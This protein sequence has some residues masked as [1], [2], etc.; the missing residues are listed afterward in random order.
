MLFL[1]E[2]LAEVIVMAWKVVFVVASQCETGL[3]VQLEE[4]RTR[5]VV[6]EIALSVP[7]CL[8]LKNV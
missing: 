7:T 8:L 5:S 2:L 1:T 3:E 6:A 4:F